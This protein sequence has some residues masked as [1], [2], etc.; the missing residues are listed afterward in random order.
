MKKLMRYFLAG[1]CVFCFVAA[2]S[3]MAATEV[4]DV[5][6]CKMPVD[7]GTDEVKV[8]K[9]DLV[10]GQ[11]RVAGRAESDGGRI[12]SVEVSLDGGNNWK[13]AEG[14]LM[15]SFSFKPEVDAV[16]QLLV[17][18]TDET[19]AASQTFR[20]DIVKVYYLEQN[21]PAIA[22]ERLRQLVEF[23]M[24]ERRGDFMRLFDDD[25]Y[26]D[27]RGDCNDLEDRVQSD[28]DLFSNMNIKYTVQS[29]LDAA[30]NVAV[31]I[32]W[33]FTSDQHQAGG[34]LTGRDIFYFSKSRGMKVVEMRS[35]TGGNS[36][37]GFTNPDQPGTVTAPGGD[38]L[39][40]GT[41]QIPNGNG[42]DFSSGL[43]ANENAP[44]NDIVAF[45]GNNRGGRGTRQPEHQWF[46]MAVEGGAVQMLQ[47]TDSLANLGTIPEP[48]GFE[49]G[50]EGDMGGAVYAVRTREGRFA[51]FQV[52]GLAN[53]ILIIR[54][55]YQPDGT[56]NF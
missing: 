29:V 4:Y 21:L 11:I 1:L 54:W 38:A 5:T 25:T 20:G 28:F 22:K 47:N 50:G 49:V 18:A 30:Q 34:P 46:I 10:Q 52:Q 15:W 33:N 16:Y 17:R 32:Y 55:I 8:N 56:R 2:A 35:V 26:R 9:E 41:A 6:V 40:N 39:P 3:A 13:K 14:T 43:V 12:A 48:N 37:F 7:D 45:N 31:Q 36:L 53:G 44:T 51:V 23:Y 24:A 27:R 19:G 42:F